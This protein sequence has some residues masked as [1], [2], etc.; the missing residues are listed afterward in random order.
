MWVVAARSAVLSVI[1][2][3]GK[4]GITIYADPLYQHLPFTAGRKFRRCVETGE[5]W[6]LHLRF[7]NSLD[8]P[9]LAS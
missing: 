6:Q 4:V 7:S 2:G 1:T 8:K 5:G 9:P 3:G